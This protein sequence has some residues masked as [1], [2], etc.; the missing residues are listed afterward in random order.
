MGF[1]GHDPFWA[2]LAAF[3]LTPACL[4]VMPYGEGKARLLFSRL[5]ASAFNLP[6]CRPFAPR[7]IPFFPFFCLYLASR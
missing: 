2:S 1:V 3:G 6:G 5:A 4:G 7:S